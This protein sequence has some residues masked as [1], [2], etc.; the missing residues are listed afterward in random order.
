MPVEKS[1][2]TLKQRFIGAIL[3]GELGRLVEGNVIVTLK[4]FKAY[5]SDIES[6]YVTSFL[7]QSTFE[8]GQHTLTHTRFVFRVRKGVY[9][10]HAGVFLFNR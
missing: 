7:P 10:V 8:P 1:G 3:R 4:E 5:F 6:E 2:V 9:R